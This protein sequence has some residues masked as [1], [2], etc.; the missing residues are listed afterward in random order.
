MAYKIRD[1]HGMNYLTFT[2]VDW[3]DVFTRV[4]YKN[5]IIESLKHCQEKKGLK[6]YAYVL[7]TNHMHLVVRAADKFPLSDIIRDFKKFT[8]LTLLKQIAIN[9][10]ESRKE[11]IL[12]RFELKSKRLSKNEKNQFWQKGNHPIMLYSP[13]VMWQKIR[14]IH[15]NPVRAGIVENA[16]DYTYSSA[17]NYT[18]KGGLI[19]VVLMDEF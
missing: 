7:M 11:W 3:I 12:P 19:N 2:V 6:I 1:Q 8:A 13:D 10:K 17:S 9:K 14:Y 5:I 15:L 18:E 4:E 16:E